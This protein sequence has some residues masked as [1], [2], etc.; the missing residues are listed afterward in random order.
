MSYLNFVERPQD[1][2][3]KT[4]VFD[5]MS[6][7]R[8]NLGVIGFFPRWRKFVCEFQP[9]CVFDPACMREIADFTEAQTEKWKASK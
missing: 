6:S 1:P 5:V 4:A 7:Q 3:R 8:T 9:K 2:N